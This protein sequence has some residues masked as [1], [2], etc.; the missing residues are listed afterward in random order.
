MKYKEID[1]NAREIIKKLNFIF[2]ENNK[3]CPIIDMIDD[4]HISFMINQLR[5][6]YGI[7]YSPKDTY[8]GIEYLEVLKNILCDALDIESASKTSF[9]DICA[10]V[11]ELKEKCDKIST[12]ETLENENYISIKRE[13]YSMLVRTERLFEDLTD[14]LEDNYGIECC[15]SISHIIDGLNNVIKEERRKAIDKH[16]E[17]DWYT[18]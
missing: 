14:A 15:N 6:D 8:V 13:N 1:D 10:K 12:G 2:N 11:R 17:E 16:I 4:I 9:H 18:P 3:D 7:F 5:E